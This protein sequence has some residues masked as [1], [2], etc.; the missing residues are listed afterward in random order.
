VMLVGVL[1]DK[2]HVARGFDALDDRL[3]VFR[4]AAIAEGEWPEG[5][6]EG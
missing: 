3:E 2:A 5:R 4:L 1:D 6:P